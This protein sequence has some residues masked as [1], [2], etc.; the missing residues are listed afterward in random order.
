MN[1]GYFFLADE[2]LLYTKWFFSLSTYVR[3]SLARKTWNPKN[4]NRYRGYY[5]TIPG[6]VDYKEAIEFGQELP[7]DDPDILTDTVLYDES[8][9]WL[10]ESLPGAIEF[11]EFVLAYYQSMSNLALE[12]S[13][14]RAIGIGKEENYFDELF[15]NKPLSTLRLMQYPVRQG[16]IPEAAQKDGVVLVSG[17]YRYS[18]CY[19]PQHILQ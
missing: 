16:P 17:A 12:L 18:F 14:L 1:F 5:P 2:L 8:N 9:V 10:P 4:D 6:V 15:L 3:M 19:F 13:H 11:K 7:P